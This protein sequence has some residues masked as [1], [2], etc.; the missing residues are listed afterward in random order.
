MNIY[1]SRAKQLQYK[2]T[3]LMPKNSAREWEINSNAIRMKNLQF[4]LAHLQWICYH[5][6][7]MEKRG[8][9]PPSSFLPVYLRL[10]SIEIHQTRHGK[11]RQAGEQVF[12][13]S[14]I[15]LIIKQSQHFGQNWHTPLDHLWEPWCSY[16]HHRMLVAS[17][18]Q[19]LCQMW[20][21]YLSIPNSAC[22]SNLFS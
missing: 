17:K 16:I 12:F 1:Y 5:Y 9:L 18:F 6:C 2:T 11:V 8:P 19:T 3:W 4:S 15:D 14:E 22:E 13:Q 20:I 10:K 7:S 21:A